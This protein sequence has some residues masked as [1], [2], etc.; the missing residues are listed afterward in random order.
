MDGPAVFHGRT[1]DGE[2]KLKLRDASGM[3]GGNRP[4]GRYFL[5]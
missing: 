3:N 1:V 4:S 5:I 2:K